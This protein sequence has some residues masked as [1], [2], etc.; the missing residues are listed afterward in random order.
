MR[1]GFGTIQLGM[2]GQ[3]LPLMQYVIHTAPKPNRFSS[4]VSKG[5]FYN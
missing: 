2:T 1:L 4:Q 5:P 3:F